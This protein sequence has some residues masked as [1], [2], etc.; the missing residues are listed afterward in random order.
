[1]TNRF[2]SRNC[3]G[4]GAK[5]SG[6]GRFLSRSAP[7]EL[8]ILQVVSD[9]LDVDVSTTVVDPVFATLLT[10]PITTIGGDLAMFFTVSGVASG[11]VNGEY[12]LLLDG[13]LLDSVA[14]SFIGP[15][16]GNSG[17]VVHVSSVLPGA[18]TVTIEWALIPGTLGGPSLSVSPV[19]S[20]N[21]E[22]ASLVVEEIL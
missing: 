5:A 16:F 20:P 22:H 15:T 1:M 2:F 7:F 9:D 18:H 19:T 13:A 11:F 17:S 8:S 10:A 21:R 6:A 3:S 4:G 14:I 12:R